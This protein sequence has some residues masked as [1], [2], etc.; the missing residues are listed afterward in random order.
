MRWQVLSREYEGMAE[1]SLVIITTPFRLIRCDQHK[2]RH[3]RD[4]SFG[5]C[6][7]LLESPLLLESILLTILGE[8][9]TDVVSH[10][11]ANHL[12]YDIK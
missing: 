11:Q 3:R 12:N 7:Y 6:S 2:S 5:S 4:G 1:R 9:A 10:G 8:E